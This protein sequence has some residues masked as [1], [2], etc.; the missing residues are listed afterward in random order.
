MSPP[1]VLLIGAGGHAR[2]LLDALLLAGAEVL[3]LLDADPALKGAAVLGYPVLGG[4]E[5]LRQRPPGSV[6][7]VNAI[8]STK[9]MARRRTLYMELRSRGHRFASVVHP[10]RH[11]SERSP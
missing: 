4:D 2:V 10:S 1:A 5:V 9:S 7:L 8:G 11:G 6:T 3:G